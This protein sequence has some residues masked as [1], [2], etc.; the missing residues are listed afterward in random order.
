[1]DFSVVILLVLISVGTAAAGYVIWLQAQHSTGNALANR[2][3]TDSVARRRPRPEVAPQ[4][5]PYRATSIR[6]TANACDAAKALDRRRFL[7]ADGNVPRLPLADCD[8]PGCNCIYVKH[9]DRR[10]HGDDRRE[11]GGMSQLRRE[12]AGE[13]D[14]RSGRD[15]RGAELAW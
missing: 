7:M 6:C 1:M 12:H 5:Y 14:R 4:P 13:P 2:A 11:I 9:N 10:R 8:T 3:T 15:R